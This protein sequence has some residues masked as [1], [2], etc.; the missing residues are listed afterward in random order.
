MIQMTGA[1]DMPEPKKGRGSIYED[2]YSGRHFVRR[3]VKQ[4]GFHYYFHRLHLYAEHGQGELKAACEAAI[5]GWSND[6]LS[7][8]QAYH[9]VF[10]PNTDVN[11]VKRC[12]SVIKKSVG[13][14]HLKSKLEQ[15]LK[16]F[17][18]EELIEF[19][20]ESFL[21]DFDPADYSLD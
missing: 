9:Q 17:S 7:M 16:V 11:H 15:A 3:L 20:L 19:A 12:G 14:D 21:N 2:G 8:T 5:K 13:T 1:P 4:G 10:A 18:K 6:E